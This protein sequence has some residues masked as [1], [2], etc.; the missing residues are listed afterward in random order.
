MIGIIVLTFFGLPDVVIYSKTGLMRYIPLVLLFI[1]VPFL[2]YKALK[3]FKLKNEISIGFAMG[4]ILVFGPLF[5]LWTN[6][7]SNLDLEKTGVIK[8]AIVKEKWYSSPRKG[9]RSEWLF[10]A[11][12]KV[13][14]IEYSTF[15]QVDKDNSLNI[16]D[17]V[18]VRYSKNNPENNDII[19]K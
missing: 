9:K 12:F 3:E 14:N 18:W 7:K 5:G 4:S 8:Y 15:S 10:I 2:L 6:L 19:E 13:D 16:G 11:K 17:T 1:L